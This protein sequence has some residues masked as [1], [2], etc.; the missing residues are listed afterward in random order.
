MTSSVISD[1]DV[2]YAVRT[3]VTVLIQKNAVFDGGI[4]TPAEFSVS[5]DNP[6]DVVISAAGRTAVLKSMQKEHLDAA[7]SRGII[8]F[9]EMKEDEVVRCSP[10]A[11]A[12]K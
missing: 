7:I 4:E 6:R 12:R 9:Y 5:P 11:L 2:L 1:Y 10:C 3:G 8:M